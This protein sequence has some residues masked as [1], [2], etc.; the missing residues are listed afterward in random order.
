MLNG[1]GLSIFP[2]GG[3]GFRPLLEN[4]YPFDAVLMGNRFKMPHD[5]ADGE[6]PGVFHR[7][8]IRHDLGNSPESAREQR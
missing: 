5:G 1:K 4:R 2:G 3:Q 6:V 7:L 8:P